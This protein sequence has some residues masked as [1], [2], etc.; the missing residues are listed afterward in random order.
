MWRRLV[1]ARP[2]EL[3]SA[4]YAAI[5]AHGLP[6][7]GAKDTVPPEKASTGYEAGPVSRAPGRADDEQVRVSVHRGSPVGY[8]T[9][10]GDH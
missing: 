1:Q 7:P 5:G 10:R 3:G 2:A 8:G 4:D 9:S 6:L